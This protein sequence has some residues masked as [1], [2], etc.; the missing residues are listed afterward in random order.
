[1][2]LQRL[3]HQFSVSLII[4]SFQRAYGAQLEGV[5]LKSMESG[6]DQL[7]RKHDPG[8]SLRTTP[9]TKKV[10]TIERHKPNSKS[11]TRSNFFDDTVAK[12][13]VA[14]ILTPEVV[15]NAL[16]E[17]EDST[18]EARVLE[19]SRIGNPSRKRNAPPAAAKNAKKT[20]RD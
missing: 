10:A 4:L 11:E 20:V 12:D 7:L 16:A 2:H 17:I 18:K 19:A 9:T 14:S 8:M 15:S 1:M 3:F 13:F 5:S 6:V